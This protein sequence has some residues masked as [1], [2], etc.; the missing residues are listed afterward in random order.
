MGGGS[1]LLS[2]AEAPCWRAPWCIITR[3][4]TLHIPGVLL[5]THVAARVGSECHWDAPLQPHS[6]ERAPL[7]HHRCCPHSMHGAGRR[8]RLWGPFGS[9]VTPSTHFRGALWPPQG[10]SC[11]RAAVAAIPARS[12]GGLCMQSDSQRFSW[13]PGHP[14]PP[15]A[16]SQPQRLNLCLC[17]LQL[18]PRSRS[19][20]RR[21]PSLR[22]STW[23]PWMWRALRGERG[24]ARETS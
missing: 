6:T 23:S 8:G 21:Q 19:S 9:S 20:P 2:T 16:R 24:S 14:S 15:S 11:S 3:G 13:A 10:L 22:C 4:C 17:L 12:Q 18:K 1:L 5:H 7:L